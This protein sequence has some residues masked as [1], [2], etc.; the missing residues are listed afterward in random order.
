M[1][2]LLTKTSK[3]NVSNAIR[4][5]PRNVC[6]RYVIRTALTIGHNRAPRPQGWGKLQ[7]GVLVRPQQA[8]AHQ[9]V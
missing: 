4:H 2:E 6:P 3:I 8:N 7:V 9:L 1:T 5:S